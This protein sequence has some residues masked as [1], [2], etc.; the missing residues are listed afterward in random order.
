MR[1]LHLCDSD[2][3]L[4][5]HD[6]ENQVGTTI[7]ERLFRSCRGATSPALAL[8][9][10]LRIISCIYGTTEYTKWS[11]QVL[12]NLPENGTS[13][14][15]VVAT[16]ALKSIE[17]C[18]N[19]YR[20]RDH[21]SP[22]IVP[23]LHDIVGLDNWKDEWKTSLFDFGGLS[24][25]VCDWTNFYPEANMA[26][27]SGDAPIIVAPFREMTRWDDICEEGVLKVSMKIPL[28]ILSLFFDVVGA[29]QLQGG[30][31]EL[32]YDEPNNPPTDVVIP[33]SGDDAW[34]GTPIYGCQ[35]PVNHRE[36]IGASTRIFNEHARPTDPNSGLLYGAGG[37][38]SGASF[39]VT[40]VV[41]FVYA[42]S[43]K[44]EGR[45]VGGE[46][47]VPA[48][49][50]LSGPKVTKASKFQ[51]YSEN[52]AEPLTVQE[53]K[54]LFATIFN[55][56]FAEAYPESMETTFLQ[57]PVNVQA[58]LIFQATL[59]GMT[60]KYNRLATIEDWV[61]LYHDLYGNHNLGRLL[62]HFPK[63][64][65][66]DALVRYCIHALRILTET[67]ISFV[68]GC[69]RAQATLLHLFS[70]KPDQSQKEALGH[71]EDTRFLKA[72][73]YFS[74][75]VSQAPNTDLLVRYK[76]S[77][78]TQVCQEVC[79]RLRA[80][81]KDIQE[82]VNA[83]SHRELVEAFVVF[84]DEMVRE[85]DPANS[86][87]APRE[88][89]NLDFQAHNDVSRDWTVRF[90]LHLLACFMKERH[91]RELV[92]SGEKMSL[93]KV[94]QEHRD[95]WME[96]A[97][98]VLSRD[99]LVKDGHIYCLGVNAAMKFSDKNPFKGDCSVGSATDRFQ[100]IILFFT[101]GLW[102]DYMGNPV[103]S[104]EPRENRVPLVGTLDAG[105][106]VEVNR[107]YFRNNGGGAGDEVYSMGNKVSRNIFVGPPPQSKL[108]P[109]TV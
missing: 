57:L 30:G 39:S 106:S 93:N 34:E 9:H 108:F 100:L 54:N 22:P 7:I 98:K 82:G 27:P 46:R 87:L 92:L 56:N 20:P 107:I 8:D 99:M 21:P 52:Y 3:N 71:R 73:R 28:T 23:S 66:L 79:A 6:Q 97:S 18:F 104:D 40:S 24:V 58:I 14:L 43:P 80:Y 44:K 49:G 102:M 16:E 63:P 4:F 95:I 67:C 65:N 5:V 10:Y 26:A 103:A 94:T 64:Q 17:A 38:S 78:E 45:D 69:S 31:Q 75:I 72:E 76:K 61:Q 70:R 68:D 35:I 86:L 91:L 74:D 12:E 88:Y 84:L 81:S 89:G 2:G 29:F 11:K 15:V 55:K 101:N 60:K 62:H 19:N 53:A 105:R 41:G 59:N 13:A 37:E 33:W 109:T 83:S 90:R 51:K 32:I 36:S 77:G 42:S 50:P 96:V 85:T 48:I 47:I 25:S 1:G